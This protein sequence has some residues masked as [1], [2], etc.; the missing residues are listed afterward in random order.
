MVNSKLSEISAIDYEPKVLSE[1]V[2]FDPEVQEVIST[3]QVVP[4]SELTL[5]HSIQYFQKV[6]P[7]WMWEPEPHNFV[8]KS[9][10]LPCDLNSYASISRANW[11]ICI[12][13]L[14]DL[15][16]VQDPSFK[17][18]YVELAFLAW[19]QNI[20]FH[21]TPCN[22]K[23]YSTLIRKCINQCCKRGENGNIIPGH[24]KA[25]CKSHGRTM[26]A[27]FISNSW[28]FIPSSTLKCL[29]LY[30]IKINSHRLSD[31]ETP[32]G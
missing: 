24:Q 20:R 27:G 14:N 31:W 29:A 22:P 7:K 16:W 26:P 12:S 8:W 5:A 17:T 11:E 23:E 15:V 18:A 10:F 1:S 25:Q 30:S 19:Y 2:E 6:F 32:F 13:F 9:D 28:P 4:P 21:E 3:E